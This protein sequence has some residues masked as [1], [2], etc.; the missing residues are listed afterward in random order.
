MKSFDT[1]D[2]IVSNRKFESSHRKDPEMEESPGDFFEVSNRKVESSHR[3]HSEMEEPP[4]DFSEVLQRQ[5][6]H[7]YSLG[8][9]LCC[10]R[11]HLPEWQAIL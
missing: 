6:P 2:L 9:Y 5:Q 7:Y 1:K 3:K 4:N 8:P 11:A 10:N